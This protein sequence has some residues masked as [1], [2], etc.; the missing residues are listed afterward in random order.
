MP[1]VEGSGRSDAKF[2][3]AV[4][5]ALVARRTEKT[6]KSRQVIEPPT[7]PAGI[8]RAKLFT[9]VPAA[10]QFGNAGFTPHATMPPPAAAVLEANVFGPGFAQT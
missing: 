5:P 2:A 4:L 6:P 8:G 9:V 3:Q 7:A 1:M 10:L